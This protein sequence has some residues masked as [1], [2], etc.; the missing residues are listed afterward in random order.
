M[1]EGKEK[2]EKKNGKR[3]LVGKNKPLA[4]HIIISL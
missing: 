1:N 2:E 3:N 4:K